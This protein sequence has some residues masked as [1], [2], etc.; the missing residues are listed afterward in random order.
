MALGGGTF[1]SMNKKIPGAYLN[2]VSLSKADATISERGTVAIGLN[3][4]WGIDSSVFTVDRDEFVKDSLKIF[5]YTYNN[6]LLKPIR[7]LFKG[8]KKLFLYKLNAGTKAACEYATAKYSGIRGNDLKIVILANADD[9]SKFDV[10]T[11][12]DITLVDEQIGIK[13]AT[14]LTDNEFVVWIDNATLTITSGTTLKSGTN[15]TVTGANHQEFLAAIE[16]YNFNILATDSLDEDTKALYVS[17][18]KRMREDSGI[19]FQTVLHNKAADYEGIINVKNSMDLVYWV[20]GAEAG[21]AINS[22]CT[23][24]TYDGE[25]EINTFYTQSQLS[26]AIDTGELAFHKV[27]DEFRILTDINSFITTADDK[28][29]E[30]KSNQTIRI[31]DQ[32]G[33]D[34]AAIFNKKYLGKIAN[35]DAGR[36]SLW[37]EIV[38]Y[39][40]DLQ[41]CRAIEGFSSSD[42]V[43]SQGD[44]KKS[45]VV[46]SQVTPVNCMEKLYMTVV[47]A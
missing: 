47:V 37:S 1:T 28:G 22:S 17:F 14:E 8:A 26:S 40:N 6:E 16:S 2:F 43:I 21:C 36:V 18:T 31:L 35:D 10:S 25:Y 27:G 41:R 3:L 7:E 5:G 9:S 34:I 45:V 29:E 42:I 39:F 12:L 38:T 33:N 24:K 30:F 13:N 23:N 19:K 4:N 32:I 44:D 46:N 15:S 11:Y 20:A